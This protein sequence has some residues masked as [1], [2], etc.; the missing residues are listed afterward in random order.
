MVLI[1][2]HS[3]L[4]AEE[5]NS[6]RAD[7]LK[8]ADD[9]GIKYHIMP[10]VDSSTTDQLLKVSK[11]HSQCFPLMGLHPTSVK[12]DFEREILHVESMFKDNK[13]FGIGEIGID[14]YW[15]K[16][17]LEQ[18]KIAFRHQ[19]RL[20]KKLKLPVVI[21]SRNSF[22][23]IFDVVDSELDSDLCGVF[24][25]FTGSLEQYH[26]IKEYKTFKVG[27]GGVVTYKNGGIG[28]ILHEIELSDILLE[29]DS[30]YLSPVPVRGSR[31]ESYNLIHIAI[32]VAEIYGL[33]VEDIAKQTFINSQ[34]LFNLPIE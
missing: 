12:A 23:E 5:F 13:F 34:E 28:N 15:D 4:F 2:T 21:H 9:A 6:D 25:C 8:K 3:H 14:L 32:K 19:L 11:Q 22:D 29:T 17:H 7:V 16:T 27:I 31:N 10:N 26:H 18:Q 33:S 30:P 20:A 1:D 24:H